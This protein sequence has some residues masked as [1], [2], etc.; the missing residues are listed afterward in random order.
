MDTF[1]QSNSEEKSNHDNS[2]ISLIILVEKRT[3]F[4]IVCGITFV[5][6]HNQNYFQ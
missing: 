1:Y 3:N 4:T 5:I 2:M 6:C